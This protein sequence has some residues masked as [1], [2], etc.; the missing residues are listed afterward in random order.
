MDVRF[1]DD[2]NVLFTEGVEVQLADDCC[3]EEDCPAGT[4]QDSRGA[5]DSTQAVVTLD[6]DESWSCFSTGFVSTSFPSGVSHHV[7]EIAPRAD[8]CQAQWNHPDTDFLCY[9]RLFQP[10]LADD[11]LVQFAAYNTAFSPPTLCMYAQ[12]NLGPGVFGFCDPLSWTFSLQKANGNPLG[13][14]TVDIQEI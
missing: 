4:C 1:D 8:K 12:A 14:I 10:T 9:V 11:R 13:E 2:G 3:C 5:S 7:F 6:L